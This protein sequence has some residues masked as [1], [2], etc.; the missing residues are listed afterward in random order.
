MSLYS[1]RHV[2]TCNQTKMAADLV[3]GSRISRFGIHGPWRK[4]KK[5]VESVYG[6]HSS[7]FI[8]LLTFLLGASCIKFDDVV[9]L[10]H[11]GRWVRGA[12]GDDLDADWFIL[13]GCR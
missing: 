12:R 13:S 3:K 9:Y 1:G 7:C 2:A 10:L 6:H 4:K 8:G 11:L 5:F